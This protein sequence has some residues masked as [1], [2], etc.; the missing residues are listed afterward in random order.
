MS[1]RPFSVNQ[2]N[3][4]VPTLE[5]IFERLDVHRTV[6]TGHY[7][8]LQILDAMW[9]EAVEQQTNPDHEEFL[10]ERRELQRASDTI[11]SVVQRDLLGQGLRLPAGG[12]ENGILDFPTTLEG[13]WVYLCWR[14]GETQISHWHEIDGGFRGRQELTDENTIAMGRLDEDI[15]DDSALDFPP[16]S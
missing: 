4:M 13:R 10:T 2:A 9:G 12:L 3:A 15:P 5:E 7:E 14:R 1:R 6:W 8:R 16:M 11:D